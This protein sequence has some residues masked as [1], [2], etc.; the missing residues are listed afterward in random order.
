MSINDIYDDDGLSD[1]LDLLIQMDHL[2][3]KE[4][5]ITKQVLDKGRGSLSDKQAYIFEQFVLKPNSQ[6]ACSRC[7]SCIPWSEMYDA[8]FEHGLCN[9][10]WHMSTKDD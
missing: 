8:K 4:L 2:E 6:G 3:G 10:C 7:G 5:G 1:F 9:W